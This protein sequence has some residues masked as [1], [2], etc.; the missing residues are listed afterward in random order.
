VERRRKLFNNRTGSQAN[1]IMG[2][3]D[4]GAIYSA[5]CLRIFTS[6]KM[7]EWKFGNKNTPLGIALIYISVSDSTYLGTYVNAMR[8]MFE[9]R[10][11]R[12]G[13][14]ECILE[15]AKRS[16]V[17]II[18]EGS[19]DSNCKEFLEEKAANYALLYEKQ[20]KNMKEASSRLPVITDQ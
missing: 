9:T 20:P 8:K 7:S 16:E 18:Y 6:D 13:E 3:D 4:M 1:P 12:R 15:G 19:V 2:S 11:I 14:L 5:S 10:K 17:D